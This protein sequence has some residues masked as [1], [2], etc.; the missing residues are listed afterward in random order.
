MLIEGLIV[1]LNQNNCPLGI[2]HYKY[3]DDKSFFELFLPKKLAKNIIPL[4][5]VLSI[6]GLIIFFIEL[7]FKI[8]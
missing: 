5:A 1:F 7:F 3:G 6:I 4:S 8:L 2:L